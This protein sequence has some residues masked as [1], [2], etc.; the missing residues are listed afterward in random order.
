METYLFLG[1]VRPER[2]QLSIQRDLTFRNLASGLD[3]TAGVSIILNQLAV[4]VQSEHI[5]DVLSLRN[6]VRAIVQDQL[7][8][9][10]Y[11]KGFAY[12]LEVTRV[13]NQGLAID[14]VFGIDTPCIAKRGESIDLQ[15]AMTRLEEMTTSPY[16]IFLGRCFNDLVS[17]MRHPDDTGFYCYRAIESLRHHCAAAQGLSDADKAV[18]WGAFRQAAGCSE[19]T[20]L[21]IKAAADPVRHGQLVGVTAEERLNLLT[22]TWDVVDGYLG[23]VTVGPVEAS[24]LGDSPA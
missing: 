18:Q 15:R 7:A 24:A 6:V 14:L 16:G 12:D 13:L 3:G 9:V 1:V 17:S 20:L 8:M 11:L 5:W 21:G 2:A 23:T 19:E 22:T 4:R 10:G